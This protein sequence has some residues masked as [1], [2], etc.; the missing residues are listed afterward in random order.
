LN[1]LVRH[2]LISDIHIPKLQKGFEYDLKVRD[3]DKS[4]LKS[5]FQATS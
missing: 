5:G 4:L 2:S 1:V 3:L